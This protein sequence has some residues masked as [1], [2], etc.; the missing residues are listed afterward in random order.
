MTWA[1]KS[2]SPPMKSLL[3]RYGTQNT[4]FR[5]MFPYDEMMTSN[6]TTSV[7]EQAGE[8]NVSGADAQTRIEVHLNIFLM[9]A[10]DF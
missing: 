7:T 10:H 4:L 1:T 2:K 3:N 8:W 5:Y 6:W 9:L